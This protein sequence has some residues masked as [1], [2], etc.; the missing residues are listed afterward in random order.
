MDSSVSLQGLRKNNIGGIDFFQIFI[1][2]S[3]S[4]AITAVLAFIISGKSTLAPGDP[5]YTFSPNFNK[6]MVVVYGFL[7]LFYKFINAKL[8][9]KKCTVC[10]KKSMGEKICYDVKNKLGVEWGVNSKPFCR[11]HMVEEFKKYFINFKGKLVVFYPDLEDKRGSFIYSY[12]P[13]EKMSG[14]KYM[15]EIHSRVENWLN[16]INGNCNKCGKTANIA[17]FAKGTFEWESNPWAPNFKKIS[18]QPEIV[19]NDC[20]ADKITFSIRSFKDKFI[21]GI[22]VPTKDDGLIFPLEI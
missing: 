15:N 10:G 16:G 20:I 17:Y 3:A 5:W 8:E 4:L 19:C 1:G 6:T 21:E 14:D 7:W 9:G 13:L 11:E 12:S 2:I 22:S 18:T